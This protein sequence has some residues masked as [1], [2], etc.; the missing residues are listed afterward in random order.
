MQ[1]AGSH[2]SR[3]LKTMAVT[4]SSRDL[5]AHFRSGG[6]AIN[7]W[8]SIPSAVTAEIMAQQ[9]DTMTIDLQHGLMDYQT[10]LSM[11][12]AIDR[13]P[14]PTLCRVPW[15]EPGIIMKALDAGFTGIICPMVNTREEAERFAAAC[16]YAP[17][18]MRSFG[19]TR[20]LAVHGPDYVG[21]ANDLV[22]TFAMVETAMA[23][24]NLDDILSVDEVDGIYIGPADLSLSLGYTPS[25]LPT[26][27]VV[28][29]AIATIRTKAKAAGKA[30][31]VHCGS[32]AMVRDMLAAGFDLATLITDARLFTSALATGL[33]EARGPA[34]ES[35]PASPAPPRRS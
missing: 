32:P 8:C 6:K 11:L 23:L 28:W 14:I 18:G 17:R 10:A 20:A 24:A 22:T 35:P 3:D 27:T 7:G 29:D 31:A 21:A 2:I 5:K 30:A 15:N 9:F 1:R 25:L 33:T 4:A 16:R 26:D 19:P 13:R 12:Q 34:A